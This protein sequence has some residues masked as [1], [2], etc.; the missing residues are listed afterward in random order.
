[1]LKLHVPISLENF[2]IVCISRIVCIVSKLYVL[3][4]ITY[5]IVLVVN[6][7]HGAYTLLCYCLTVYMISVKTSSFQVSN[8]YFKGEVTVCRT[9]LF[10]YC[11]FSCIGSRLSIFDHVMHVWWP[12]RFTSFNFFPLPR[13]LLRCDLSDT[14][15]IINS[16]KLFFF[17]SPRCNWIEYKRQDS[18]WYIPI[19]SVWVVA[20]ELVPA[21]CLIN[22]DRRVLTTVLD[23][24]ESLWLNKAMTVTPKNTSEHLYRHKLFFP[25]VHENV[26]IK[27]NFSLIS[28]RS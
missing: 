11:R 9:R 4:S 8:Q 21:M 20:C 26:D 5:S 14:M 18:T 28:Q 6:N 22:W 15:I 10:T 7:A 13:N 3:I 16:Y 17:F 25:Q 19:H 2:G 1:M 24:L 27:K 12:Q 23:H